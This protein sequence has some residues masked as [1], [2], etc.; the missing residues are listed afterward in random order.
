MVTG[1]PDI[2]VYW[3]IVVVPVLARPVYA[4]PRVV[5]A[6]ETTVKVPRAEMAGVKVTVSPIT[7][8]FVLE[9]VRFRGFGD[10]AAE[11]T[12]DN[13]PCVITVPAGMV[14]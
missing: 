12:F 6:F 8:P 4:R 7:K 10:V 14:A 3:G 5:D 11:V 1:L 13:W 2:V 9:T